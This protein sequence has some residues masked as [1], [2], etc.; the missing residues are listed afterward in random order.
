MH[1]ISS[2]WVNEHE[3]SARAVGLTTC[4]ACHG[5]DYRGTVLSR[6]AADRTFNT[7]YG[8]KQ[9]TRGTEVSCY[10]CHNGVNSSNPSTHA[11]PAVANASLTVPA[12]GSASLT[13]S[14]TGTGSTVR[15]GRQ[16]GHGAVSIEG[17]VATYHADSGFIGPDYFTYMASDSGGY[18]DS[19][20]AGVISVTVGSS[21]F[22]SLDSDGDGLTDLVEYALGTSPAF[23]TTS[24][25]GS[26]AIEA[27]N[28]QRYLTLTIPR[29]LPP[30]DAN[31][32]IEVS[33]DLQNWTP[34]TIVTNTQ[35]L[36]KA[37]DLL[38]ANG[39]IRRF[40]RLKV[41]RP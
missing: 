37:R 5:T 13:L 35:S 27:F 18:V 11:P 3:D 20:S 16:P 22:G 29:F 1:S 19:A 38:P 6:A 39:D 36:I 14:A 10:V 21:A 25:V 8:T 31:V 28:G 41:S 12:N 24:G 4:Q 17:N 34:A 40:I 2:N 33:G 15:I 32:S 30:A 23:P 9:F 7:K 26:P